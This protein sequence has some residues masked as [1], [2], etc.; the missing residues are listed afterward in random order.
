MRLGN[1]QKRTK[2]NFIKLHRKI[3]H[4]ERVFLVQDFGSHTQ[5]QGHNKRSSRF[6]SV[7]IKA[8]INFMQR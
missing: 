8:L 6:F 5:G 7:T 4:C 2:A 3:R 1:S